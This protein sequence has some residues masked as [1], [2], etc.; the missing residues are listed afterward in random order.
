MTAIATDGRGNELL[1]LTS[2]VAGDPS[3]MTGALVVAANLDGATLLVHDVWRDQWEL[4]GGGIEAGESLL[5]TAQREAFEESGQRISDARGSVKQ[6]T[7]S[8]PATLL[9]PP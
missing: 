9:V 1:A 7:L 3:P 4:P 6:R 8:P 5:D 2:E